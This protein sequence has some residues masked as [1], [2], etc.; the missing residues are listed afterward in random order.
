MD[1]RISLVFWE[2]LKLEEDPFIRN[3]KIF[4]ACLICSIMICGFAV[5]NIKEKQRN[6]LEEAKPQV[7]C[8]SIVCAPLTVKKV[9][10]SGVK[11]SRLNKRHMEQQ[12]APIILQAASRYQV[13]PALV[14]A[15]IMAESGYNSR[16][17]SKKGAGGLMQ[18]MPNTAAALG[19]EDVF[20]PKHNINGGVK[21]F[22]QLVLKF[23]GDIRLALAAYNAGI[24]RVKQ[25]QDVPPFKATQ[26]YVKKVFEYY[27]YYKKEMNEDLENA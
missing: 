16:A 1:I 26:Y 24:K 4:G 9:E 17:V 7:A 21:Y 18:L 27:H 6:T 5:L 25:Y 22:K 8:K 11:K 15:I 23:K 13:D 2:V 10:K 19:V 12:V 14:K 20:D 3:V